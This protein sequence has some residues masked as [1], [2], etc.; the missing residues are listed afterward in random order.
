VTVLAGGKPFLRMQTDGLWV[1]GQNDDE[2]EDNSHWAINITTLAHG[3]VCW[4]RVPGTNTLL[5]EVMNSMLKPRPDCPAPI[6][7]T[8]F[9]DQRSFD[10]RCIS[11]KASG[12]EVQHKQSS[13][14]GLQAIDGLLANIQ[15]QLA[16][17][18]AHPCP[19]VTLHSDYYNNKK[20]G[21]KVYVPIYRVVGWVDMGGNAAEPEKPAVTA[22]P[23]RQ[24]P[25][26]F[27]NQDNLK[28]PPKGWGKE[29]FPLEEVE[30]PAVTLDRPKARTRPAPPPPAEPVATAQLHTGQRRRPV[31]R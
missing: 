28:Q 26:P 7:G 2:V 24:E 15:E 16:H 23:K 5:G 18:P 1:Y 20:H 12:L 11:G 14:G 30:T 19:V 4:H 3:W 29:T 22:M 21:S 31:A 27:D 13:Y 8:D 17:D 10:L 25:F 6:Q 9:K